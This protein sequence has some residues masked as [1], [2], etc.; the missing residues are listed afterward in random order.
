MIN[1]L[2]IIYFFTFFM[3]FEYFI[4]LNALN[5]DILNNLYVLIELYKFSVNVNIMK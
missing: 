5:N 3:N 4:N 2:N 1:N